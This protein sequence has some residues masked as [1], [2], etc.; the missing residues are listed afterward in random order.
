[1]ETW[2]EMKARH[3]RESIET[4]QCLADDYTLAEASRILNMEYRTLVRLTEHY[5]IE[6]KKKYLGR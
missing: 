1:M 3:R 5:E 6:F 2:P 4:I